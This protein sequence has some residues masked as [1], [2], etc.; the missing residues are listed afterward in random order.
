[1]ELKSK[2]VEVA[3]SAGELC[4]WL[5]DVRNFESLMPESISKFEVIGEKAFVFAL[6]GMPEI[7]LEV[8]SVNNPQQVSLGAI[9]DKI[10]FNLVGDFEAINDQ[11]CNA[12]LTFSG[13][14]NPMMSMMI[15]GPINS[16]LE[17]LISNISKL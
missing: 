3:R 6:K 8:K 1:M 13:D 10:P 16:F 2:Q 12:T 4:D 15:K 11:S 9:S 7:G 17:T 5:S 14:F